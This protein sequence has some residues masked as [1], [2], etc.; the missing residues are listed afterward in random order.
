MIWFFKKMYYRIL[1]PNHHPFRTGKKINFVFIHINKTAGTSISKNLGFYSKRHYK[2]NE[3]QELTG[4]DWHNAFT[5]TVVRNPYDRAVSQFEYARL[6][7]DCNIR[8]QNISFDEW[9]KLTYKEKRPFFRKAGQKF[10]STQKEWLL[11][12]NGKIDIDYIVRIEN[13][14]DDYKVV[15]DI[16]GIKEKLPYLNKTERKSYKKYYSKESKKIIEDYFRDDFEEF[17]Y[18]LE[19]F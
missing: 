13:L 14:I 12:K 1:P 2:V 15:Q 8:T 3:V 9:I 7:N 4:T 10:F 6:N 19:K 18:K 5:F 16:I 11:N 17:N